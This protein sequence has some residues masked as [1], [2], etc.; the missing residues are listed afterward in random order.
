MQ[1]QPLDAMDNFSRSNN[2]HKYHDLNIFG[3]E[4]D[5]NKSRKDATPTSL[6]TMD[7]FSSSYCTLVWHFNCCYTYNLMNNLIF[8]MKATTTF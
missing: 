7:N 6:K 3:Q 1:H 8:N 5:W 4:D 2:N